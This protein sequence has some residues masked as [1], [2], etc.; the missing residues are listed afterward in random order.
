MKKCQINDVKSLGVN[1]DFGEC[2]E[3]D[4]YEYYDSNADKRYYICI[5]HFDHFMEI[6]GLFFNIECPNCQLTILS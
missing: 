3:T 1:Y 2:K 5:K 4:L 6:T